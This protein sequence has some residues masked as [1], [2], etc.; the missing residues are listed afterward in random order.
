[1]KRG[2]MNNRKTVNYMSKHI[3]YILGDI[4]MTTWNSYNDDNDVLFDKIWGCMGE[5]FLIIL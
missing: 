3:S 2:F 1:V 4:T 5:K